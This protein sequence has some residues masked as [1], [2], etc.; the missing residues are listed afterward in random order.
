[1]AA[2]IKGPMKGTSLNVDE[3]DIKVFNGPGVFGSFDDGNMGSIFF[4]P[5]MSLP[6][7]LICL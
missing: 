7:L 1:M 2:P 4:L 5:P 6:G 3:V